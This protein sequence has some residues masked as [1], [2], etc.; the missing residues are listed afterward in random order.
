MEIVNK[1]IELL[2]NRKEYSVELES[3]NLVIN[4]NNQCIPK[5]LFLYF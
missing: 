5:K 1:Q 4:K 2:L 3:S